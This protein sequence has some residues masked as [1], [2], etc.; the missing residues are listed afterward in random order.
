LEE[1]KGVHNYAEVA[2]ALTGGG[3]TIIANAPPRP[4][5]SQALFWRQRIPGRS[6]QSG[7]YS[8]ADHAA[9]FFCIPVIRLYSTSSES[10]IQIEITVYTEI[11]YCINL[12]FSHWQ[13]TVDLQ[14]Q[15]FLH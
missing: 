10:S 14:F 5:D 9:V 7:H 6:A 2:G 4:V 3:L 15:S 13:K 8:N 12:I 11:V 1:G